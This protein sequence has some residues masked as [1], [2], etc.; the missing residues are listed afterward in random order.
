LGKTRV[1]KEESSKR[2]GGIDGVEEISAEYLEYLSPTLL[3]ICSWIVALMALALRRSG[4]RL[5]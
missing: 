1:G 5:T 3:L 2:S 4:D